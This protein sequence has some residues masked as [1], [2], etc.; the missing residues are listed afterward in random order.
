MKGATQV[1]NLSW[2]HQLCSPVMLQYSVPLTETVLKQVQALGS[3]ISTSPQAVT[4]ADFMIAKSMAKRETM[5]HLVHYN[6][7]RDVVEVFC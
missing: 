6:S 2:L 5:D 4:Q 3:Q 7:E 1:E